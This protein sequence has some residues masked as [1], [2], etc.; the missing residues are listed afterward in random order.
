M[1]V[2]LS[3]LLKWLILLYEF[4]LEKN[5]F[6]FLKSRSSLSRHPGKRFP[7]GKTS[8]CKG[9]EARKAGEGGGMAEWGEGLGSRRLYRRWG[10]LGHFWEVGMYDPGGWGKT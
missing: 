10:G 7:G 5:A 1:W 6:N 4:Y 3:C 2:P 9:V 8:T